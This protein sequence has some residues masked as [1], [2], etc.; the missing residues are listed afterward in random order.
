MTD[1]LPGLDVVTDPDVL[2]GL[3]HDEAEWA[4]A[5][6]PVAAVRPRTTEEVQRIVAACAERD[7]PVVARGAGTGLSGGANAVD[8]CVVVDL[9]K[10]NRILEVDA[11]NMIAVVQPGVVNDDLKAAV[12]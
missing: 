10:M 7:I 11:D 5:G 6:R 8:G 2:A 3:A 4:P 12:A 1:L 9:S